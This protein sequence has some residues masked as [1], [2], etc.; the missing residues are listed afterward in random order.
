MI[1]QGHLGI[2]SKLNNSKLSFRLKK[3]KCIQ[4]KHFLKYYIGSFKH[5]FS[6]YTTQ[7]LTQKDQKYSRL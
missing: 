1:A 4:Y 6:V 5:F 2:C 3:I 7:T